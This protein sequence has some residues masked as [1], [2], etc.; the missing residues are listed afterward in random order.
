[1]ATTNAKSGDLLIAEPFASDKSFE[2]SVVLLCEHNEE[3]S[4]GLVWN[5]TAELML[6]D[7]LDDDVYPDIPLF[8]GGPVSQNTLH[9]IHRRPDLIERSTKVL[10][11]VY[12]GGNF[13][14]VRKML[15]VGSLPLRDIRFFLG[16]AGWNE[17]QLN[18][19]LKQ[20]AWIVSRNDVD[21]LFDTPVEQFWRSTLRQ[22]G[23][24]YKVLSNYPLD[25][26]L[27]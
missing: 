27:N 10:D 7:V 18:D 11:G 13:Q 16:Y 2:R 6:A 25:P 8:F 1:M 23:G 12:W 4:F 19:E 24:E 14:E 22:M 3:G 26:R 9:F 5:K 21:F 15:N 20:N 17:E